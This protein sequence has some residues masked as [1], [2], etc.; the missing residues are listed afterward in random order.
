V[1]GIAANG[2]KRQRPRQ[3]VEG[4][5]GAGGAHL[6]ADDSH[7]LPVREMEANENYEEAVRLGNAGKIAEAKK[8]LDDI[9]AQ[10]AAR[11]AKA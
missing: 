1:L 5:P 4:R 11:K 8:A 7:L 9:R 6:P 10:V 3:E 2:R